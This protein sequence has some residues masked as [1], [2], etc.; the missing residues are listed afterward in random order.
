VLALRRRS[1]GD[2]HED[3]HRS[4]MD[5]FDHRRKQYCHSIA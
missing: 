5:I 4:A 3:T 1:L 2:G